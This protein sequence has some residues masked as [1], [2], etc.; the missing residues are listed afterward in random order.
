MKFDLMLTGVGGEGVLT[1]GVVVMRAAQEQ[2]LYT[3][4]VQL[5]G[6]AQRG[7]TIPTYVRFGDE[8]EIH[9]PAPMK[10]DCDLVMAF[11]PIEAVRAVKYARKDKTKFIINDYP[12]M[13]IYG[14]LSDAAYP[15]MEEIKNRIE[16]FAKDIKVY[17]ADER[18]REEFGNI[19]Y[20]NVM[21][22]GTAI[23][24]EELPIK[25]KNMEKAIKKMVPREIDKNLEALEIGL[26]LGREK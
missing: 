22:I 3:R 14:N 24:A 21:L 8:E 13:P 9:S 5:H 2:D 4:G 10:A 26:K 16:P 20:G 17:D 19:I 7:G 6:L 23:G 15:D 25:K 18:S 1:T 11:E 12:Y